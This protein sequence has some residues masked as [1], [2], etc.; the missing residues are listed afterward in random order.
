MRWRRKR[1]GYNRQVREDRIRQLAAI[2]DLP[3]LM[4]IRIR[5]GRPR[6]GPL[7]VAPAA[8]PVR[9]SVVKRLA[10]DRSLE[11]PAPARRKRSE[12]ST[13]KITTTA[14]SSSTGRRPIAE[15]C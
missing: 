14:G 9:A 8:L 15:G 3:I 2:R 12:F 10:G 6:L 11:S 13:R 1:V 4:E 5:L 7:R